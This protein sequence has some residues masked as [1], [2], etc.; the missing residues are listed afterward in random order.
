M[1]RR[2]KYLFLISSINLYR[3]CL[4]SFVPVLA[5]S[6]NL[7]SFL[8]VYLCTLPTEVFID[9]P[10][11]HFLRPCFTRANQLSSCKITASLLTTLFQSDFIF[12][13]PHFAVQVSVLHF[14]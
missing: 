3:T 14:K 13:E 1:A 8:P 2:F 7:N 11:V 6:L 4:Y 9:T 10:P 5:L 12:L